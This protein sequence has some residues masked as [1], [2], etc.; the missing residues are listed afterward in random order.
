[1]YKFL[2]MLNLLLKIDVNCKQQNKITKVSVYLN[3]MQ[4]SV[5]NN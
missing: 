3:D 1:M 2:N 5:P 4:T